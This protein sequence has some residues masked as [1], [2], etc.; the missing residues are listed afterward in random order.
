MR[1]YYLRS[2]QHNQVDCCGIAV[3]GIAVSDSGAAIDYDF[4]VP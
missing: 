3:P 1:R 2:R 4:K